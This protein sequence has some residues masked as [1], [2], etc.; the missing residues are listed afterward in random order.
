MTLLWVCGHSL[1]SAVGVRQSDEVG[2]CSGESYEVALVGV[3]Y[4]QFRITRSWG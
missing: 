2:H 4:T 1:F 3:A